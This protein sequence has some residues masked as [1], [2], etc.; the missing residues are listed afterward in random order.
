[1]NDSGL[2]FTSSL[3]W[4][5]DVIMTQ[6]VSPMPC[7]ITRGTEALDPWLDPHDDPHSS[8]RTAD[9]EMRRSA[10]EKLMLQSQSE[11]LNT[12]TVSRTRF[13]EEKTWNKEV[14]KWSSHSDFCST[15]H[16][17]CQIHFYGAQ[18]YK[19]MKIRKQFHCKITIN[20]PRY[21]FICD[22]YNRKPRFC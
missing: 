21:R 8:S 9:T 4:S 1:M 20:A 7:H 22:T 18:T 2:S 13:Q 16:L 11:D 12:F 14:N 5:M 6:C 3:N 17:K 10:A 15:T 19:S